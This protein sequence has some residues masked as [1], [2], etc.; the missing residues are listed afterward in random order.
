MANWCPNCGSMLF[1]GDD[2]KKNSQDCYCLN[3][4]KKYIATF[5]MK[6]V[7]KDE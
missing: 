2:I 3:C 7:R 1:W 6:E 4:G 5:N